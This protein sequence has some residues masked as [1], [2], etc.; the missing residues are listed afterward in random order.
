MTGFL[1]HVCTLSLP[2]PLTTHTH[3][4]STHIFSL[5]RLS[6]FYISGVFFP[7]YS[8]Y[9]PPPPFPSTSFVSH[10]TPFSPASL[11]FALDVLPP[12][13]APLTLVLLFLLLFLFFLCL[14]YFRSFFLPLLI[15]ILH[16]LLL[17]LL[18]LAFAIPQ[19]HASFSSVPHPLLLFYLFLFLSYPLIDCLFFPVLLAFALASFPHAPPLPIPA[20]PPAVSAPPNPV[21]RPPASLFLSFEDRACPVYSFHLKHKLNISECLQCR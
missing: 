3:P 5:S 16:L 1:T 13:L 10:A 2:S 18:F 11:R 12:P 6:L 19:P 7:V 4:P 20:P 9:Y 21:P 17:F 15:S 8:I 14:F